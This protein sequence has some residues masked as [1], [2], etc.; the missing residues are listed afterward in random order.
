VTQRPTRPVTGGI[1]QRVSAA[2][3]DSKSASPIRIQVVGSGTPAW[4]LQYQ[5]VSLRKTLRGYNFGNYGTVVM[6][7]DDVQAVSDGATIVRVVSDFRWFGAY[8][9]PGTDAR[10]DNAYAR[11]NGPHWATLKRIVKALAAKGIW[12]ILTFDSDCA[13]N[14]GQ[15][16]AAYCTANV[17][18]TVAWPNG[19]N[20]FTSP[21]LEA[22][23]RGIW[24]FAA[25]ELLD[26][27]YIFAYEIGSE[28]MVDQGVFDAS[29]AP[30]LRSFYRKVIGDIRLIDKKTPFIIGGRNGYDKTTIPEVILSE[31]TDVIYTWDYL[32]N[33]LSLITPIPSV[34][35]TV[36]ANNVPLF[37]NQM[38]SKTSDDPSDFAFCAGWA[39]ANARGIITTW[40]Q[41]KDKTASANGYG[42]RYDNGAGGYT[43]KPRLTKFQYFAAQTLAALE[44]AA[45]A[46]ATAAGAVL[47]YVKADF[48]NAF[49][50]SAGTT[51]VTAAGQPVGL[52]NPVVG[53]G[54]TLLQAT[55]AARPTVTTPTYTIDQRPTMLF[56]AVNTYLQGSGVY[57]ASGDDMTVI[58]AG[59]PSASSTVQT[60]IDVG[61]STATDHYPRLGCSAG[62][63]PQATWEGDDA[64]VRT[65]LGVTPTQN[66]PCVMAATKA[67]NT[68]TLFVNGVADGTPDANAVGTIA[69]MN[70]LRVGGTT[71]NT[72]N[73]AGQIALICVCKG[74]MTDPQRQAIER[75]GAYLV[76][77]GYQL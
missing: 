9:T 63:V 31:R 58:A 40:W 5:G 36:M 6:P 55:G 4:D 8:G 70:R 54:L 3:H 17:G 43:D 32:S 38:G 30:A 56:D 12:V 50:D 39:V 48:S 13:I 42:L 45:Q 29:W 60:F 52:L 10:D 34:F 71:T 25:Y 66:F 57:Y 62:R 47:F 68:K 74:G 49:Q 37:L 16:D 46:A 21:E 64:V 67:T 27:P 44:S 59:I 11:F 22:M 72:P 28:P 1:T 18:G 65:V 53:A 26:C 35:D 19:Y 76:G 73:F 7:G 75:F 77:A 41:D 14:G 23:V 24:T 69:T 15:S 51:P 2:L 33:G 61:N 20:V